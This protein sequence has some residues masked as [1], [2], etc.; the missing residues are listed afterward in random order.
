[1][2]SDQYDQLYEG[3]DSMN[4]RQELIDYIVKYYRSINDDLGS[5]ENRWQLC[6]YSELQNAIL[7]IRLKKSEITKEMYDAQFHYDVY[8][9]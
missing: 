1:M 6:S 7:V 3:E 5:E 4:T 8:S 2:H 9:Y